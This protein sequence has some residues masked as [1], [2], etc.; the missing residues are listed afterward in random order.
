MASADADAEKDIPVPF[1]AQNIAAASEVFAQTRECTADEAAGL[2]QFGKFLGCPVLVE[3]ASR[4]VADKGPS[5][6]ATAEDASLKRAAPEEAAEEVAEEAEAKVDTPAKAKRA[7]K[8]KQVEEAPVSATAVDDVVAKVVEVLKS[9][10]WQE[11]NIDIKDPVV[12]QAFEKI[13]VSRDREIRPLKDKVQRCGRC[14]GLTWA[15]STFICDECELPICGN[16]EAHRCEQCT[17]KY[18]DCTTVGTCVNGC[19]HTFCEHCLPKDQICFLGGEIFCDRDGMGD[20]GDCKSY[21]CYAHYQAYLADPSR[22]VKTGEC[23]HKP[24]QTICRHCCSHANIEFDEDF[25]ADV[26]EQTKAYRY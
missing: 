25:L 4:A 18:C 5:K 14:Q 23:V 12:K 3:K 22:R 19:G 20:C 13:L 10:N 21:V 7:K 2:A 11:S 9:G 17:K 15:A 6:E 26:A 24:K 8:S 16:H 1:S